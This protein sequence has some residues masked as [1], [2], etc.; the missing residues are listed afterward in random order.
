MPPVFVDPARTHEFQSAAAFEKWL[1]KHHA[2]EREVWIEIH[3]RW[4]L[5][6]ADPDAGV[7]IDG[8][9][10]QDDGDVDSGSPVDAA[11]D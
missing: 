3:E 6:P 8:S 10:A 4:R 11:R 1:S 7:P 5:S 2:S 9:A